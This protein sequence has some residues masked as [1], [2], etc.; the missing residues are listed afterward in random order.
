MP[1]K[2]RSKNL[3]R[4]RKCSGSKEGGEP[5]KKKKKEP[6]VLKPPQKTN[7]TIHEQPP[8]EEPSDLATTAVQD[9]GAPVNE[10]EF[11]DVVLGDIPPKGLLDNPNIRCKQ[12]ESKRIC[13][14]YIFINVHHAP[15]REKWS[16]KNGVSAQI[17]K[18]LAIPEGTCI[19]KELEDIMSCL[20][21]GIEYDPSVRPGRGRQAV[22]KRGSVVEQTIANLV[23]TGS[24]IEE[25]T[26]LLNEELKEKH[27]TNDCDSP[28]VLYSVSSVYTCIK[29]L[30]PKVSKIKLR[31]Q[32]RVDE[33]SPW[34]KARLGWATQLLIK[35]GL[36]EEDP[37]KDYYTKSKLESLEISQIV[38][39][40]ET[41][42]KCVIG[43]GAGRDFVFVEASKT[44]EQQR[45]PGVDS[46]TQVPIQH[47]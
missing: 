9:D 41:H 27:A 8:L 35:L 4:R 42:T 39:W 46:E 13:I 45:L 33:N 17:K 22:V 37:T 26:N 40:D 44:C 12:I 25:A 11:E 43:A 32:G 47:N 21:Q 3:A 6:G 10:L 16:G 5:A 2:A 34:A 24:S 36:L 31:S 19:K 29:S 1:K 30:K 28:L 14:E 20:E 15:P 18:A 7:P 38:F 23:E